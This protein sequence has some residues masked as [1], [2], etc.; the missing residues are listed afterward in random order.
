MRGGKLKEDAQ[1]Q[2]LLTWLV[3]S[4]ELGAISYSK[5]KFAIRISGC[6][7]L[8][9]LLASFESDSPLLLPWPHT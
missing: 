7:S 8:L 2:G 5:R 9:W 4:V 6:I 1:V 3:L